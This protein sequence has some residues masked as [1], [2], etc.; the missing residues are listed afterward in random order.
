MLF[1]PSAWMLLRINPLWRDIDAYNQVTLPP[2]PMTILQFSP[3]YC[4]GARLPLY[5]GYVYETIGARDR[6]SFSTFLSFPNLTDSGVFLLVACQHLLLFGAQ[7]FLLQSIQAKP[8]TKVILAVFLALNASFYTYTHSVGAEALSLSATLF[9]VGCA[10][11]L[12][13]RRD[14]KTSAWAWFG[15]GLIF[16]VLSRQVNAVLAMLLPTAILLQAGVE[17]VRSA[18]RHSTACFSRRLIKRRLFLCGL[19]LVVAALSFAV[20]ARTVRYIC[21]ASKIKYRSTIGQP[22]VWRLNFLAQMD[23]GARTAMLG[24][25]AEQ[26]KDPVVQQ[27]IAATPSGIAGPGKWDPQACTNKFV[28]VIEASGV[29]TDLSYHLDLYRNRLAR[30]FL[31]SGE[32]SFLTVVRT[33]FLAALNF[34]QRELA[35]F[36]IATTRYCFSR[37]REMP[38]LARLATFRGPNADAILAAQDGINYFRLLDIRFRTLLLFWA[39]LTVVVSTLKAGK[40][41]VLVSLSLISTATIMVWTICFLSE[42][43]PRFTLPFWALYVAAMLLTVG[44]ICDAALGRISRR[45]F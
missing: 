40:N 19:S 29:Q 7:W 31:L 11:R 41:I 16:C 12:S 22:F 30:I 9:L 5:L 37:I 3:L 18:F 27:M 17:T 15:L 34:S 42:L 20:T 13:R 6:I 35:T 26:T 44:S 4:F 21:R 1:A 38:Q 8:I 14:I 2:G 28:E 39:A 43:L 45:A 33:D 24:R 32:P 36:P 23:D 25:L 10:L